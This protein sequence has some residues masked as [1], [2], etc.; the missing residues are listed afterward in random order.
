MYESWCDS[1]SQI[2][3]SFLYV[4]TI[5]YL[6][7]Y[8]CVSTPVEAYIRPIFRLVKL[9]FG[10]T[11][12]CHTHI[13]DFRISFKFHVT[14]SGCRDFVVKICMVYMFSYFALFFSFYSFKH[15]KKM[16]FIFIFI[17]LLH[18]YQSTSTTHFNFNNG[19]FYN[20]FYMEIYCLITRIRYL[21]MLVYN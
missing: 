16:D 17:G 8:T 6:P 7:V 10:M 15:N 20:T 13:S 1:E 9:F 5:P 12:I 2:G 11:C 4:T 14:L 3:S 19:T 21:N 18:Y